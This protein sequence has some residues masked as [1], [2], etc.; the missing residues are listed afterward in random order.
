MRN[1]FLTTITVAVCLAAGVAQP[2]RAQDDT[3]RIPRSAP[4]SGARFALAPDPTEQLAGGQYPPQT[5]EDL[6]SE[7]L[8]LA[9]SVQEFAAFAPAQLVDTD[10]LQRA[11]AQIQQM[12]AQY[13]NTLRKVI[14]PAKLHVRLQR[15][16]AVIAKYPR[17]RP[18]INRNTNMAQGVLPADSPGFPDPNDNASESCT[19]LVG[20]TNSAD[21]TSVT[22]YPTAVVLAADVVFFAADSVRELAQDACKQDVAGENTSLACIIVDTIWIAAKAVDLSIHFCDDDLTGAVGDASYLRLGAINDE[23]GTLQGSVNS[24]SNQVSNVGAQVSALDTHLSTVETDILNALAA[25]DAHMTMLLNVLQASVDLANQ[26]LLKTIAGELQIMKLDLTPDGSRILAPSILTCT[27][28][29]CPTN[30]LAN[31][32]GPGGA[33]TWNNVGPLP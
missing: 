5:L 9:D 24:V 11:R 25:H 23:I 19:S 28:S 33:C 16:R 14:D 13:L 17:S 32:T 18:D 31:C 3:R 30:L 21:A 10:S 4:R 1:K 27:G 22:R 29:N 7:L 15:A 8:N 20:T 2:L 12:P 26:R 6:R